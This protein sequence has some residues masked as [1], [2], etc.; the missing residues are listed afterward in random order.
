[1]QEISFEQFKGMEFSPY[2]VYGLDLDYQQHYSIQN[3]L[4][5]KTAEN[6]LVLLL[7]EKNYV[8]Y[9]SI[10]SVLSQ[11]NLFLSG[12]GVSQ[13]NTPEIIRRRNEVSVIKNSENQI[14]I[15][16]ILKKDNINYIYIYN[17]EVIS[18]MSGL[19]KNPVL[20]EVFSNDSG[21]IYKVN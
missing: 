1:M 16:T 2:Q 14:E 21:K 10:A 12:E 13:L 4:K 11:R 8:V 7:G 15:N 19:W 20:K 18:S 6:S 3:Y 17:D 9:S 5:N